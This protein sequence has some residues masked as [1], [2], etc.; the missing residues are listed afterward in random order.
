MVKEK[1]P[2]SNHR[3]VINKIIESSDLVVSYNGISFD[4]KFLK[5]VGI[6]I[7]IQ[8][9]FDVMK[10][11]SYWIWHEYND[12]FK[13]YK[14]KKLVDCADYYNYKFEAHDSL[15]DARATLHCFKCMLDK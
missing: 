10:E 12:Y 7:D 5:E 15:E 6:C 13:D 14:W 11:F 1:L 2:I 9:Q 3:S 8:P 4:N